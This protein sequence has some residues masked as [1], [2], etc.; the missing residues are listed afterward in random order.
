MHK[1]VPGILFAL[2]GQ[3]LDPAGET[4]PVWMLDRLGSENLRRNFG[5]AIRAPIDDAHY[6]TG[7]PAFV[8]LR[9]KRLLEE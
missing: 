1:L 9:K 6:L 8:Q 4:A 5:S 3:I 7:G 2:L